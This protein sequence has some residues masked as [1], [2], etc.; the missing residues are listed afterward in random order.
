M[1]APCASPT[2]M[3]FKIALKRKSL[4]NSSLAYLHPLCAP[5]KVLCLR[6]RSQ[7]QLHAEAMLRPSQHFAG[8]S[9]QRLDVPYHKSEGNT[10]AALSAFA[11]AHPVILEVFA[12]TA[13]VTSCL[14]HLGFTS[15]FGVDIDSSKSVSTCRVADLSTAEGQNLCLQW[16]RLRSDSEPDGLTNLTGKN[17]TRVQLA[18]ATYRFLADLIIELLP[19]GIIILV[20]NPQR[21]IFWLTSFWSKVQS[22]F[23]YISCEACAF[24]GR[25]PKKTAFAVSRPGFE[26]LQKFCPGPECQK[27]HLPWG[28]SGQGSTGFATSEET[29][30]PPQMAMQIALCFAHILHTSGHPLKPSSFDSSDARYAALT[31]RAVSG[32][33]PKAARIPPLVSEHARIVV[34]RSDT[35]L[36]LPCDFMQRLPV[37]WQVP[38][39]AQCDVRIVP[40]KAQLLRN[41][42]VPA[43]QGIGKFEL[44]FGVPW[45][46]DQF[47]QQR[48]SSQ[49]I[50]SFY[51]GAQSNSLHFA[52]HDPKPSSA[53][54]I[55]EVEGVG[56]SGPLA[57]KR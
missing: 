25:R 48:K 24:G 11:I 33:Q 26:S 40:P 17:L 18:N 4:D 39:G 19:R 7:V 54:Q 38:A 52:L 51:A 10:C 31:A 12:G 20:E 42:F 29:A 22:H 49:E 46:E 23:H 6:S 55:S 56:A 21:S 27:Q 44:A 36:P 2:T 41:N 35:K 15:S 37:P 8:D 50:A 28:Q 1:C 14:K 45:T 30:Y 13:R 3:A 53:T 32:E 34:V 47:V 16:A 43:N 5:M 57:R 9:Q